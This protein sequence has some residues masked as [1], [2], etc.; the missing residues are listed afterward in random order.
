MYWWSQ[1][2]AVLRTTCSAARRRYV[3][4]RRRRRRDPAEEARL[5]A[6][7]REA[8]K[9][10]QESISRAKD[11]AW[12]ELLESLKGNP[13]GR[14]YKVARGKLRNR[15]P[16]ATE[17]LQPEFLTRVVDTLFPDPPS[18]SS[19]SMPSLEVVQEASVVPP[20]I[21]DEE[22]GFIVER[23]RGRRKA[24]GPD[25]IPGGVLNL[26]LHFMGP[27]LRGLFDRCLA[28][29][30]FPNLWKEGRLAIGPLCCWTTRGRC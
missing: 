15:G 23:L 22:W 10:L 7:Y 30:R 2:L 5:Y 14:P 6:S 21:N 9:T 12:G 18:L 17:T 27:E 8:R 25:G 20:P 16:P 29:G 24:P 26:A 4:S 13:W 11:R 28:V 3:R 19:P 1:D